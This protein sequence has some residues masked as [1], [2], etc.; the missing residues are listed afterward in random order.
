MLYSLEGSH[1]IAALNN[2]G[3]TLHLRVEYLHKSFEIPLYQ[4]SAFSS[5]FVYSII[6][7]YQHELLSI[8]M[9]NSFMTVFPECPA[10]FFIVVKKNI[11][12]I[13]FSLIDG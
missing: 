7:L 8:L 12:N 5:P 9:L 2:W 13:V 6:F 10:S 1:C 11:L 4:T 3:H